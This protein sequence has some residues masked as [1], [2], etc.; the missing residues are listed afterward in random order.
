[1]GDT[2]ELMD[3]QSK[4][5]RPLMH[6]RKDTPTIEWRYCKGMFPLIRFAISECHVERLSNVVNNNIYAG[7]LLP[8]SLS[9]EAE[10]W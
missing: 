6:G 7:C 8:F 2:D 3:S 1:M 10:Q 4:R 5:F 9:F